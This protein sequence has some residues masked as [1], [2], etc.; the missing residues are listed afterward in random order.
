MGQ[1]TYRISRL[2]SFITIIV[3][4]YWVY[5]AYNHYLIGRINYTYEMILEEIDFMQNVS[6]TSIASTFILLTFNWIAFGKIS[7]WIKK[8][9]PKEEE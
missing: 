5:I 3:W 9:A 6:Y 2:I 1:V 7:V 4:G 8:P